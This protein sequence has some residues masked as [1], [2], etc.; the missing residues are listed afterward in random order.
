MERPERH[1]HLLE[2]LG[3]SA[4]P[5]VGRGGSPRELRARG[6]LAY[7]GLKGIEW[8]WQSI[9]GAMTKPRSEGE[10]T[11]KNPTDRGKSGAKLSV[12]TDGAGVPLG[13]SVSG[14]NELDKRL[15]GETLRSRPVLDPEPTVGSPQH[16]CGD[17]WYDY[18]DV[19][20]VWSCGATRRTSRHGARRRGRRRRSPGIGP[21]A[22]W[23]R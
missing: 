22:G 21:V 19:R 7:D 15:V 3:P 5:G 16:L 1:R 20:G 13:V 10:K 8:E 9:D 2:L 18:A 14:A 23:W 12:L 4:V 6:L 17:K 11:G